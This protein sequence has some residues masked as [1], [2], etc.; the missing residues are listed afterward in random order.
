MDTVVPPPPPGLPGNIVRVF[1]S[2]P[3]TLVVDQLRKINSQRDD[4]N[5]EACNVACNKNHPLLSPVTYEG[6]ME[7]ISFPEVFSFFSLSLSLGE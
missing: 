2:V 1:N 4:E 3:S 5:E 6:E 7:E